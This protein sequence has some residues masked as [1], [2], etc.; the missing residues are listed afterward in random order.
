ML[1]ADIDL[2]TSRLQQLL[3]N[4]LKKAILK[5][6][7]N[8]AFLYK[9]RMA[10]FSRKYK[11]NNDICRQLGA[12]VLACTAQTFGSI[13]P[14]GEK[15]WQHGD[16]RFSLPQL[17]AIFKLTHLIHSLSS[18]FF[19]FLTHLS[20]LPQRL[21]NKWCAHLPERSSTDQFEFGQQDG[22]DNDD[23]EH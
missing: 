21:E 4:V 2:P 3:L 14:D 6:D 9:H 19:L 16:N 20:R 12:L 5:L 7:E 10:T 13:R 23:D 11:L 1:W 18:F 8:L 22:S 17:L 15:T